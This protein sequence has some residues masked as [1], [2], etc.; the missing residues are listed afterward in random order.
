MIHVPNETCRMSGSN[1]FF[2]GLMP[3]VALWNRVGFLTRLQEDVLLRINWLY[4]TLQLMYSACCLTAWPE[5]ETSCRGGK[6][7]TISL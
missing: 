3:V 1:I 7:Q 2:S 5:K 6:A 4:I